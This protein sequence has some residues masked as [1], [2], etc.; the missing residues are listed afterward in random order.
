MAD[1]NDTLFIDVEHDGHRTVVRLGGE[2]DLA[3]APE[4]GRVLRD[5]NREIIVDLAELEFIDDAGV[6]RPLGC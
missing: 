3:T 2:V 6:G 1:S 4:L 5:A